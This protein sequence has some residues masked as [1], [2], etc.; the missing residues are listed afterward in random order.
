MSQPE[1]HERM[2]RTIRLDDE[3]IAEI[4]EN[5]DANDVPLDSGRQAQRYRYRIKALV[6]HMQQPGFSTPVAF[7]VPG[8]NI[9]SEG[10]SFLHGGFVHPGTRCLVQLITSYGAWANVGGTIVRCGLIEGSVHEVGVR[11]D[12]EI[13]PAVYCVDAV[14]SQVLLAEDD[15][16]IAR[17]ARFH[18]EQLNAEV[19]LAENGEEA[20]DMALKGNYDLVLM[21]IEMPVMDGLEAVKLLRSRGYIGTIAAATA[22]TQPEDS[23]TCLSAGCD[24]YIPKPFSRTELA[25]LLISLRQEPLFSSFHDDP[26]MKSLVREFVAELPGRIRRMEE[27]IAKEDANAV[28]SVA[29]SLKAEGT[30]YGFDIITEVAEGVEQAVLDGTS[31]T[32]IKKDVDRLAKLC[33]QVRTPKA[34]APPTRTPS[35]KAVVGKDGVITVAPPPDAEGSPD[36]V[37]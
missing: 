31:L 4:L 6:V 23:E 10:L 33:S 2:V 26:A 1:V 17:L 36:D 30:S 15:P 18:L 37:V 27:A 8:R 11:L 12:H 13:D 21:D 32:A 5:L 20:V 16:S 34:A 35:A 14:R 19:D 22:L 28:K 25:D 3:R 24:K 9:S 7:L 29:R